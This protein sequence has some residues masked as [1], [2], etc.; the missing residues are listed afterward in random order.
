MNLVI[1]LVAQFIR[2]LA[3]PWTMSLLQYSLSFPLLTNQ[4]WD[5]QIYYSNMFGSGK[6]KCYW[7]LLKEYV[8]SFR[9]SFLFARGFSLSIP[10]T[11][12]FLRVIL[13]C[14]KHYCTHFCTKLIRKNCLSPFISFLDRCHLQFFGTI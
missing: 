8:I 12:I 4:R 6:L 9:A 1:I 11:T 7:P 2:S 10:S 14:L 5:G 3:N 13:S